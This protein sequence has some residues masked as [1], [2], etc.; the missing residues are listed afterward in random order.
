VVYKTICRK[1]YRECTFSFYWNKDFFKD[2]MSYTGWSLFGSVA[3]ICKNQGINVLLNQFFNP[4]IVASRGIASQVSGAVT[5]FSSNFANALG[6]QI[7]KSYAGEK[8]SE[9]LHLMFRGIK[10]T[11]FLMY[12]FTLPLLL[13]MP[14]VLSLWLKNIPEYT[15]LFTRLVLIESLINSVSN[16]T[17]QAIQAT[18]HN[19]MYQSVI[20]GIFLLN[21]PVSLI[22]LVFGAPAYFVLIISVIITEIAVILRLFILRHLVAFSIMRFFREVLLPI[23]SVSILAAILPMLLFCLFKQSILRLCMMILLSIIS[24]GICIYTVGFDGIERNAVKNIILNK[25]RKN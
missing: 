11:Y 1:K 24:T 21:L 12:I 9:M 4:V 15:V 7:I 2:I 16:P 23:V 19:K 8:T 25:I 22:A 6:P 13:E 14:V 3:W 18:G 20:G 17:S 5:G 10:G